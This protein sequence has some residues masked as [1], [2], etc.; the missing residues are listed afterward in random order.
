M[1]TLEI[2]AAL[3]VAAVVFIAVKLIGLVLHIALIAAAIGLIAGFAVARAFR[4]PG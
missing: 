1:R 3:I 4:R 2:F